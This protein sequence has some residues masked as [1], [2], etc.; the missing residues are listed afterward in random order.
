VIGL[1]GL[2]QEEELAL[3]VEGVVV[4]GDEREAINRGTG[5]DRQERIEVAADGV[6][7]NITV[8]RR[9]PGPPHRVD[10]ATGTFAGRLARLRGCAGIAGRGRDE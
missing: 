8:G 6:D 4:C 7:L 5:I 10:L 9:G 1:P 2:G 3:G